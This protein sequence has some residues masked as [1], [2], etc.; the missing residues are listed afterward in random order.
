MRGVENIPWLYD[1]FCS[2][3]EWRGLSRWRD[4]LVGPAKGRV[5]EV[6]CG[7]GRNLPRYVEHG[8]LVAMEPR[9]EMLEKARARSHG[10]LFV[11]GSAEAL[12]FRDGAFDTVVSSLVF[13]SVPRPGVGEGAGRD[14]TGVDVGGRRVPQ[15]PRHRGGGGGRGLRHRGRR[16]PE[17]GQHAALRGAA[18]VGHAPSAAFRTRGR[19]CRRRARRG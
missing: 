15:Q 11:Q 6:G 2:L 3:I 1:L 4:W 17:A 12:P 8:V 5:L 7:T 14:S 16:A 13:C 10:A 19:G 9:A 18:T